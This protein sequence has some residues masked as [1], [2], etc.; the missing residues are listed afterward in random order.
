MNTDDRIELV[1][2]VNKDLR[3]AASAL[4]SSEARYLVDSYYDAQELRIRTS[5]QM[6]E[7]SKAGEPNEIIEWN[8]ENY[9]TI[10]G[11]IKSTLNQYVKSTEAGQWMLSIHGI[12]PVISAGLLAHIDINKAPTVGHIWRFAGLDPT[13]KWE[14]KTRRPWNAD[15]KVLTWKIGQSFMKLRG[16]DN[17]VYGK[18][19]EERKAYEIDRNEAGGNAE[20]AARQ[21]TEK[22]YAKNDTRDKLESGKLSDGQIDARARRYAVKLFLSHFHHVLFESTFKKAPPKPYIIEHG[23]H[24]HFLAPPNWPMANE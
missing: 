24:T 17:D 23:G 18:V 13:V 15:L 10:E 19:Y 12:G 8:M 1:T 9:M 6:R 3:N 16:Y 5:A 22:N 4:S 14:K 21:L 2:K 7:S 20:T 11:G